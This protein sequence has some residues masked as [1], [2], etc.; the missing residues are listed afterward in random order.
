M[1]Y[2]SECI[3]TQ[4]TANAGIKKHVKVAIEALY[5]EF[6]QMYD[7]DV[8]EGQDA[9]KLTTSQKRGALWAISVI[10]EK[11]CGKIKGQT[12]A[13]SRPQRALYTKEETMSPTVSTNALMLSI[14]IDAHEGRDIA[15]ANVTGV[16]LHAAPNDFT[17][18]KVKGASMDI[19]CSV[20]EKYK[21]FVTYKRGKKVIY[22]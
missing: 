1:K 10:K 11:R 22:L 21:P 14:M 9:S 8:V 18:L 16:Y 13:D 17:L 2:I 7:L 4:M 19:M 20:S 6:L 12:I 15:T 5:Q 3:M